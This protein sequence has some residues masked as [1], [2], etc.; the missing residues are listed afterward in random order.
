RFEASAGT[1][2]RIAIDGK[3]DE[4]AQFELE[5]EAPPGN[6]DFASAKALSPTTP[7]SQGSSTRLASKPAGEPA[8]AGEPG[9]HSVWCS[10]TPSSAGPVDIT[11]CGHSPSV[12]TLL[13]VYTGAK[14][15]A[16]TPVASNDDATGEPAN[17]LCESPSNY[18]EVEFDAASATT[19][20]IA[21]DTKGGAGRFG[22][23][24]ERAP[25]ND[26]FANA[27]PL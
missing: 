15:D 13:A 8:H 14:V 27:T 10:W 25:E 9:R 23:A 18:S 1:S 5:L 22:L 6:D 19:Y 2:Y 16:L 7:I 17:E 3:G 4:V 11:A 20:R 12:D 21:V 24:F 26:D